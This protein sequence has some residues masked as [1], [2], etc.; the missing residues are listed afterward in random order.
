MDATKKMVDLLDIAQSTLTS[1]VVPA[2]TKHGRYN[3]LMVA[4]ALRIVARHFGVSEHDSSGFTCADDLLD[5]A[6]VVCGIRAGQFDE[7]S[8]MRETLVL[9]LRKRLV[10]Q[11]LVDNPRVLEQFVKNSSQ[12]H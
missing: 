3:A 11:L 5:D 9:S 4:N 2:L 6:A 10:R 7:G 12:A 1:E 8:A